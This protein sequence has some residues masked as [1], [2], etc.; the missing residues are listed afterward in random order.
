MIDVM[1]IH[2]G[3]NVCEGLHNAG[4]GRHSA[5]AQ[6]LQLLSTRESEPPETSENKG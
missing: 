1:H 2:T 5:R 3:D 4:T 6:K